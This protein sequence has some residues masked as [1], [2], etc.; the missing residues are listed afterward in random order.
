MSVAPAIRVV[1]AVGLEGVA[2]IRALF[3]EY[4][5]SLDFALCFQGF[6]AELDGLPGEYAAPRGR[7]LLA[8]AGDEAAGCVGLCPLPEAGVCE[9]RRLYVRPDFRGHWI[10][11]VLTDA[12]IAAARGM[13]CG[14]VYLH[15]LPE[16]MGKAMAIYRRAGFTE[17]EP[18]L[19]VP[20]EGAVYFALDMRAAA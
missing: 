14:R 18:Y 19:A 8:M 11:N 12:A 9:V 20:V 15:T 4:A 13:G 2:L 17:I 7:L 3:L 5:R 10:A 6:E 1:E 16:T